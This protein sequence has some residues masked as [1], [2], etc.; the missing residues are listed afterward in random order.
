MVVCNKKERPCVRLRRNKEYYQ[1]ELKKNAQRGKEKGYN[2]TEKKKKENEIKRKYY[3]KITD[4]G[5]P[6]QMW[7]DAEE[8]YLKQNYKKPRLVI[9]MH[10]SRS[11]ASVSRKLQRMGI[12]KYNKYI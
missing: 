10:L 2:Y 3:Y 1:N 4:A 7:T 8:R 11:W 12:R 6:R 5:Q 9:C